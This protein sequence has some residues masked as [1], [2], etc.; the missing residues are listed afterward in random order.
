MCELIFF[1]TIYKTPQQA[2]VKTP[3]TFKPELAGKSKKQSVLESLGLDDD[4]VAAVESEE[5][6]PA[7]NTVTSE[8]HGTIC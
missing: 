4:E 2:E 6:E 3:V 1:L 8:L 7:D 5:E